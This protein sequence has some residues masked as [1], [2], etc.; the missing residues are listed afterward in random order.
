MDIIKNQKSN[1]TK[2]LSFF[3]RMI[4]TPT[5]ENKENYRKI[6]NE[7]T[8]SVRCAKRDYNFKKLGKNPSMKYFI[9]F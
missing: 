6:R 4:C 9:K 3:Q 2:G 1:E 8:H 7:V 5:E